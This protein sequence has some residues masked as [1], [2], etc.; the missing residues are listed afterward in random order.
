MSIMSEEEQY[1]AIIKETVAETMNKHI[2]R[3]N[4]SSDILSKEI[5]RTS[6]ILKIY[7]LQN[8]I[9]A[10][11]KKDYE[12]AKKIISSFIEVNEKILKEKI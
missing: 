2:K 1:K 7:L 4:E 3:M 12:K 9:E 5:K 8:A 11:D 6:C 10:I